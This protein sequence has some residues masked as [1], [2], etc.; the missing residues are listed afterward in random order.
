[1]AG[2]AGTGVEAGT[3]VSGT[4]SAGTGVSGTGSAVD[5]AVESKW[6]LPPVTT[7]L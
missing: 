1:V 2:V 6:A 3:D 7:L 5:M 4:G